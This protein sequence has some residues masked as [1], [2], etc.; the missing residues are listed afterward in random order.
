M[1]EIYGYFYAIYILGAVLG[2]LVMGVAYDLN[3]S[4]QPALMTL[5]L[6]LLTAAVLLIR[7]GVLRPDKK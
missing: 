4:Y 3:G 6:F 5:V 7:L 1:S 2:P